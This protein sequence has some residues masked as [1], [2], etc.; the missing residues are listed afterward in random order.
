MCVYTDIMEYIDQLAFM[1]E[2]GT[3]DDSLHYSGKSVRILH[4]KHNRII[5]T[6]NE[7]EVVILLLWDNRRNDDYMHKQLLDR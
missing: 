4:S 2:L 3:Q 6:A 7:A 5:Y 1:P